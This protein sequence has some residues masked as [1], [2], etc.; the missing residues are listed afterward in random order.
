MSEV[1][2]DSSVTAAGNRHKLDVYARTPF[3]E[4]TAEMDDESPSIKST[5]RKLIT[6]LEFY[7]DRYQKDVS[8]LDNK[9][10]DALDTLLISILHLKHKSVHRR[11][12]M[13]ECLRYWYQWKKSVA[14]ETSIHYS[15]VNTLF[16]DTSIILLSKLNRR[17][18]ATKRL[19]AKII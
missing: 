12:Q 15:D 11:I 10:D 7:K 4:S 18:K 9:P 2:Q 16:D 8:Q 17:E 3:V 13:Q 14:Q 19:G 6:V 5:Y 1:W